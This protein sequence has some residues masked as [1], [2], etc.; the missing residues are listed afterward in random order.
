MF[1][2]IFIIGRFLYGDYNENRQ[3]KV[4][5]EEYTS[6]FWFASK[7]FNDWLLPFLIIGTEERGRFMIINFV[8]RPD[9]SSFIIFYFA[10]SV[11]YFII[12]KFILL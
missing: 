12:V 4:E 5:R 9:P 11:P 7:I 6:L 8:F 3:G 1:L 2:I 10:T